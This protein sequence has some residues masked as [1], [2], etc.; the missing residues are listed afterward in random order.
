[1]KDISDEDTYKW[2]DYYDLSNEEDISSEESR[3]LYDNYESFKQRYTEIE[4]LASGGMKLISRAYD[5]KAGR[6]VAIAQLKTDNKHQFS[7]FIAEARLTA[8]LQHPNIIKVFDVGYQDELPFFSMELKLGDTLE[9]IISSLNGDN[10]NYIKAYSRKT[11]LEIFVKVCD[12]V[13]YSHSAGVI[14]LD[15]KPDNIQVGEHGEVLLCDWGLA[16]YI[17]EVQEGIEPLM[18]QGFLVGE[19]LDHHIKGTPGYMAPEQICNKAKVGIQSD[20][21]S[22]GALLYKILTY[23]APF[24][25]SIDEIMQNTVRGS[26]AP[27]EKIKDIP[28]SLNAVVMKAMSSEIEKRYKSVNCLKKDVTNYQ[29]GYSTSA[30]KTS[31][32]NEILLFYYRNKKVCLTAAC[33]VVLIICIAAIFIARLHSEKRRAQES[34]RS[35]L[36]A[37]IAARDSAQQALE[38]YHKYLEEKELADISLGS[39]PSSVLSKVKE[40]FI[41]NFYSDPKKTVDETLNSLRRIEES[42]DFEPGLYEFLGDVL[43]IRQ[44]FDECYKV[45]QKGFGRDLTNNEPLFAALEAIAGYKS[46][47][48]PAPISILEKLI[49]GLDGNFNMQLLKLLYYDRLFRGNTPEHLKLMK[50]VMKANNPQWNMTD[51]EYDAK[52]KT[53]TL[54]G[55]LKRLSIVNYDMNRENKHFIS[56]FSAVEVENLVIRENQLFRV[57]TGLDLKLK[58]LDLQGMKIHSKAQFYNKRVTKKLI[59]SEKLIMPGHIRKIQ[60]NGLEVILK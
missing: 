43:F 41:T 22:L 27:P 59:V 14:H 44:E 53:L 26:F 56:L 31:V 49:N 2:N 58:T 40:N 23:S 11:L 54:R 57:S 7:S 50:L 52:S 8:G 25:G 3:K 4:K 12:A 51:F 19:T 20:V 46:K 6:Y 21:Y 36:K 5:N 24:K 48:R 37:E 33:S 16:K 1:M 32:L 29:D 39:D 55:Q 10:E 15:I 38:N 13:S 17:G 28:A 9:E 60:Q 34:E 30:E 47:G 42:N 35:A 18:E 45:M